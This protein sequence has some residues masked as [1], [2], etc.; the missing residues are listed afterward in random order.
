ME[1]DEIDNTP[2]DAPVTDTEA[3]CPEFTASFLDRCYLPLF[4]SKTLLELSNSSWS[5]SLGVADFKVQPFLRGCKWSPDGTC[6]LAVVN[7]DGMHVTELNRE[8]YAGEVKSCR[9]IDV[10]ES[11]IHVREAGMIYD[12]CWYPGMNSA[13]P[14]TCWYVDRKDNLI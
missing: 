10:M 2:Q 1:T 12:F 7:D 8:L 13:V 14:E 3:V 11:V 4:T 9:I 5:R 6:C